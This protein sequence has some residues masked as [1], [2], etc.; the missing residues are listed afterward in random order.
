MLKKQTL[1]FLDICGA[2]L[3]DWSVTY[4]SLGAVDFATRSWPVVAMDM[5]SNAIAA[6]RFLRD[7]ANPLVE[8]TCDLTKRMLRA[9]CTHAACLDGTSPGRKKSHEKP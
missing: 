9:A 6:E 3:Q 4:V 7:L 5:I 8:C 1:V 2:L